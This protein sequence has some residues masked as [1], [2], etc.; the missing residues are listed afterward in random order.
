MFLWV[1]SCGFTMKLRRPCVR[2][3]TVE[4]EHQP[5]LTLDFAQ[6]DLECKTNEV[7]EKSAALFQVRTDLDGAVRALSLFNEYFDK[8]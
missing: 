2:T 5:Q 1:S 8:L 4:F 6:K 3:R 7:S